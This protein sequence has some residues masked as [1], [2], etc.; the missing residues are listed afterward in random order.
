MT[1]STKAGNDGGK[2][3]PVYTQLVKCIEC[4]IND[5]P[6]IATMAADPICQK[7]VDRR[8]EKKK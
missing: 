4:K 7:C 5:A 1:P 2:V 8:R 6:Y 3:E